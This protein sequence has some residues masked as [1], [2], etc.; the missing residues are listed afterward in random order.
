MA[1]PERVA[2]RAWLMCWRQAAW[3]QQREVPTQHNLHAHFNR[4]FN[5]PHISDQPSNTSTLP[6]HPLVP[7]LSVADYCNLFTT[8]QQIT[9]GFLW[10]RDSHCYAIFAIVCAPCENSPAGSPVLCLYDNVV[11]LLVL[12][13]VA[14]RWIELYVCL[15]QIP[16]LTHV[17]SRFRQ[18]YQLVSE[19]TCLAP[20]RFGVKSFPMIPGITCAA[21]GSQ[22]NPLH[23]DRAGML[24]NHSQYNIQ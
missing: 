21:I 13:T 22:I 19:T 16:L 18:P 14:W 24:L 5:Q 8:T 2:G 10:F 1:T 7:V 3:Q 11:C 9:C 15:S 12:G 6:L 23:R 4:D 17:L 20:L